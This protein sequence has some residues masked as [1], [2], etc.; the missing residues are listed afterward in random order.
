MTNMDTIFD[1]VLVKF[2]KQ[3]T[4][5]GMELEQ[6]VCNIFDD[7]F[8]NEDE[9][10]SFDGTLSAFSLMMLE[11]L[12]LKKPVGSALLDLLMPASTKEGYDIYNMIDELEGSISRRKDVK[13]K[14]KVCYSNG[15]LCRA[16]VGTDCRVLKTITRK[17]EE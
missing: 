2:L 10:P 4:E 14:S 11:G 12:G 17:R 9:V 7:M 5:E 8:V 13:P 16:A 6:V 3:A 15:G 1:D